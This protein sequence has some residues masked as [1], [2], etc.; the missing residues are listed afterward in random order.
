[1]IIKLDGLREQYANGP[2]N[3]EIR[4]AI[5]NLENSVNTTKREVESLKLRARNE[6]IRNTF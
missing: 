4:T 6:E 1:M 3:Q 2:K 5:L